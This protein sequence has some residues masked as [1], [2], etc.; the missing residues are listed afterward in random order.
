MRWGAAIAAEKWLLR[1]QRGYIGQRKV[2]KGCHT[3]QEKGDC[4]EQACIHMQGCIPV[5][6]L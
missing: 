6:A 2:K 3:K 5:E 1:K 4:E